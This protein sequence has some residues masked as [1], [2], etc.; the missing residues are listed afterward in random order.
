[1]TEPTNPE[2]CRNTA[3]QP[4]P[5]QQGA[6]ER[7]RYRR[8]QQR[9][10]EASLTRAE[11]PRVDREVEEIL[12]FIRAW[13]PYGGAPAEEILVRFGMTPSRFR[14]KLHEIRALDHIAKDMTE[15]P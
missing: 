9:R 7:R 6:T 4:S 3:S 10:R 11:R 15:N 1:M 5:G 14:E 12:E 2:S 8:W 13:T